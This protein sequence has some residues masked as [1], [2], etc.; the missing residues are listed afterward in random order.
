MN[1]F[2]AIV[3]STMTILASTSSAFASTYAPSS[4][5]LCTRD[6]NA[7]GRASTCQCPTTTES[8]AFYDQRVGA[9]VSS[10]L[11]DF[12]EVEGTIAPQ[13]NRAGITIGYTLTTEANEVFVVVAP[14]MIRAQFEDESFLAQKF[15]VAA[16]VI[17]KTEDNINR[18]A[19]LIFDSLELAE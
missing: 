10:D 16:E 7:W 5:L 13:I 18:P 15:K 6:Y 3:F 19:I 12:A 1:K 9:C 11:M 2:V 17:H 4:T 8:E 14:V